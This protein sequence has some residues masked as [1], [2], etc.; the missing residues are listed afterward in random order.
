MFYEKNHACIIEMEPKMAP[1]S[2]SS[3]NGNGH[4]LFVYSI[5]WSYSFET[6]SIF[7]IF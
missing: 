7:L 4:Y 2:S 3:K 1:E 6:G 5:I